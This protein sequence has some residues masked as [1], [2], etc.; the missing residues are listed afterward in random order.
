MEDIK[1]E[2]AVR[3]AD[4]LQAHYIASDPKATFTVLNPSAPKDYNPQ[5]TEWVSGDLVDY[6]LVKPGGGL[7][8][9]MSYL[10]ISSVEEGA[11]YFKR[12]TRYPDMVCEML[13]RYEWGDLKYTTKKEFKNLKKKIS[14]K[15]PKASKT[16]Q[17]KHGTHT[18]IFE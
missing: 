17:I 8:L 13:A 14:R 7:E 16:I 12:T 11:E 2:A 1:I 4:N 10:S 5:A 15:G 18:V 6:N 9:P 3:S